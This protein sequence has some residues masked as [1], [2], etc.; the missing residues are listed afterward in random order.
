MQNVFSVNACTSPQ[1][2]ECI[3]L[4][5]G[6]VMFLR[7]KHDCLEREV[8]QHRQEVTS[9]QEKLDSVTKVKYCTKISFAKR[10]WGQTFSSL[11]FVFHILFFILYQ[12]FDMSVEDLSETL[13]QI[14]VR[15]LV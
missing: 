5:S 12:E 6:M 3:F 10:S 2:I 1:Q 9:L 7:E 4:S 15:C 8:L 13:L 14:K 11:E